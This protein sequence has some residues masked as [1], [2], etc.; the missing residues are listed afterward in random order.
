VILPDVNLIVYAH[1]VDE[2]HHEPYRA[3]LEELC[4]GPAPFAL[5][6]LVGAAFVRIVTNHRIYADPTPLPVALGAL[7]ALAA[8][9]SCRVVAPG[10]DHLRH[11]AA[12][13]R[14]ADATGKLVADA[15]HAAVAVEHGCTLA[16]RD[17][18]FARFARAGLRF[19]HL[20]LG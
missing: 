4:A 15:Q 3:W 12:L 20:V 13:C 14:A 17:R 2:A 6:V 8:R 9:P 18:D 5:S 19:S 16:S 1:R 10:P 7:E 11:L